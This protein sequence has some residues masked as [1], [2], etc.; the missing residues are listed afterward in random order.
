MLE[1]F[2]H[3]VQSAGY[4]MAGL[5]FLLRSE[6]A[7]RIEASVIVLAFLGFLAMGRSLVEFLILLVLACVLLAVE[8]LNTA[9]EV[10]VDRISP[11]YSQFGKI[12]KDLGSAAV[13]LTLTAGGLFILGV[14]ADYF[15]I[16][17]LW[18]PPSEWQ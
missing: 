2:R 5:A 15:D 3:I 9:V 14:V 11:E 10:L 7:A 16:I 12:A 1:A 13:F 17:T 6:I 4:S 18:V 8:S